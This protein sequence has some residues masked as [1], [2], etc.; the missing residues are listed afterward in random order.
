MIVSK[1]VLFSL[2]VIGCI[3][4]GFAGL[5]GAVPS[6]IDLYGNLRDSEPGTENLINRSVESNVRRLIP[7]LTGQAGDVLWV[8][9]KEDYF[10]SFQ[11]ELATGFDSLAVTIQKA[12]DVGIEVYP[13]VIANA[14][15]RIASDH[16]EWKTLDRNG[17]PGDLSNFV[18]SKSWG[19]KLSGWPFNW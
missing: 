11:D 14:G 2:I 9:D 7:S 6:E 16:P 8:T 4:S 10:L 15:G 12:H 17:A 3:L 13:S 18:C 19:E 1:S 5:T